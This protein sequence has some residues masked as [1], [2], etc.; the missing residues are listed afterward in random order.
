MMIPEKRKS[1][2]LLVE[3]FWRKGYLTVKRRFGTYL[4][5]PNEIGGFEVD[6]VAR[7]KKNYALGITLSPDDLNNS[8]IT[9]KITYLA[10]R[11]TSFSSSRV[12]LFVGVP[13][14]FIAAAK[15]RLKILPANITANIQLIAIMERKINIPPSR[16]RRLFA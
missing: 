8:E 2:D 10:T 3:Q 13:L 6:V 5:E 14:E 11:Q 1:V 7:Q 15:E 16:E 9:E 4:P 12:K